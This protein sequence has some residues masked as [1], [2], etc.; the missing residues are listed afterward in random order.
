[1]ASFAHALESTDRIY[2]EDAIIE[3][4]RSIIAD[5]MVKHPM[6]AQDQHQPTNLAGANS[7]CFVIGADTQLGVY[8]CLS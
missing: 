4:Y 2:D 5:R 6:L 7:F 1:M 3:Q 8:I